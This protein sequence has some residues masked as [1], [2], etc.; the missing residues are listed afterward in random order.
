MNKPRGNLKSTAKMAQE[1]HWERLGQI[2]SMMGLINYIIHKNQHLPSGVK[3]S[4]IGAHKCLS[5]AHERELQN[6]QFIN[7]NLPRGF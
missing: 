5:A 6:N 7:L 4:L 1:K 3:I 2:T